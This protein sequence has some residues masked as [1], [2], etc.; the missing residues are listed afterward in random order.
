MRPNF[1]INAYRIAEIYISES[2]CLVGAD[3][4]ALTVATL[5]QK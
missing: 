5:L 4:F 3:A 1:C 2:L